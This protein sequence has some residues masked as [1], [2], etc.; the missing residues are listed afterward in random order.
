VWH[1]RRR[2]SPHYP[3]ASHGCLHE[4]AGLL[5]NR[6]AAGVLQKSLDEERAANEAFTNLAHAGSKRDASREFGS[7]SFRQSSVRRPAVAKRRSR[8]VTVGGRG[9]AASFR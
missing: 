4:C 9:P 1:H 6:K 2:S 5:G 7:G 3:I 8:A